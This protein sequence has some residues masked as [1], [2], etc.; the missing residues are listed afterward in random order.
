MFKRVVICLLF[1]AFCL[2]AG[3][4]ETN[5]IV[6]HR[7]TDHVDADVRGMALWPLLE[8]I[9]KQAAWHVFVEPDTTHTSSAKFKDLPSGDALKMLLGDLNFAL[10][11]Q[12]NAIPRLYVFRTA[13]KNATQPVLPPQTSPRHVPNELLV[14]LKP[15]TDIDALA[16]S[17]GAKITGRNDKLGLYRLLFDNATAT[18]AALGQL[19]SNSD[20]TADYN[21]IYDAPPPIQPLASASAAPLS[22]TLNPPGDTGKVIV[23]LIDTPVQSLGSS[24]DKFMLKQVSVAGDATVNNTDPLHGTAMAYTIL[25]AIAQQSPGG[26]SVQILPVDVYGANANATTWNVALG[27]QQAVNG[28]A[29]VLNLSLG[30]PNDSPILANVLQQA[31]AAGITVYAAAGNQPVTTP[32]YPADDKGVISVTA[33]QQ[34][35]QIAPYANYGLW[36]TLALPGA[37]VVFFSGQ[38]WGVQG[39]SVSTAYASGIFSGTWAATGA[40]GQQ[41]ISAM[42]RKWVVPGK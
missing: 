26:S 36:V 38:A 6:W 29:N 34:P 21:Y 15:G 10:V 24:L 31:V 30:G 22:L 18:D 32:M 27:V 12:S 25:S 39:T 8:Q 13:I 3:A 17:L 14:K 19:K 37:S 28:G 16:K 40:N 11:P 2:G 20:V 9:A 41:I 35:G 42:Q 1:A 5:A 33:L 4:A 23:G 7:A